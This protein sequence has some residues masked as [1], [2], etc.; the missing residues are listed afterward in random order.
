MGSARKDP[1]GVQP[2]PVTGSRQPVPGN[3]EVRRRS[4]LATRLLEDEWIEHAPQRAII[5]E[6]LRYRDD[7]K[8]RLGRPLSGRRLSQFSQ[9]GKSRTMEQLK[10][11]LAAEREAA[12]LPP[13]PY[14]VVI[15]ELDR[16][17]TLKGFYQEV[18]KQLDDE[19]WNEKVSA[20]VLENRIADFVRRLGVEL[21][22]ADEVQHLRSKAKEAGEVT[23]RLKV[24]LDRGVVPLVLVG[25]EDAIEFFR[26]NGK[27][28][29]RLGRP[30]ELTPLDPQRTKGDAR[31]FK[32]FCGAVDDLLVTSG[33]FGMRSGLTDHA[34]LDSLLKV[35]SG[36]I[37]R[38][39]RLVG[40]AAPDAVWRG[41]DRIE[42]YDLS[43]ATREFAIGAGWLTDD[44]FS[45]KPA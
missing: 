11:E 43:R 22:I 16:R 32:L 38:V 9:A 19:F 30:L 34:M 14:Q 31:L 35:S 40:I 5:D 36:H 7:T 1:F 21:L 18:L 27:L 10:R 37:G 13:N 33:V 42:P 28:A 6:L 3:A 29:A 25:D 20:K 24:F 41:A 17:M 8:D 45:A 2:K 4:S 23:D 26:Q 39:A 12:G 44:P 15:V